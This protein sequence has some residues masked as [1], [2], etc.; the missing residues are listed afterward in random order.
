MRVAKYLLIGVG[1]LVALFVG[2]AVVVGTLE[3]LGIIEPSSDRGRSSS[4]PGDDKNSV[5]DGAER[6]AN[7]DRSGRPLLRVT[8]V[9][10][11][12]TV[13][14]D[15][16]KR[17]RLIG[18]DT[19]EEG[20][21][22]SN[23]ATRFTRQELEGNLVGYE[24][25]A[26]RRDRYG[27]TLAYLYP[28]ERMHEIALLNRGLARVLTIAPNDKYAAQFRRAARTAREGS[29]GAAGVCQ[30][31]ATAARKAERLR[32]RRA[33]AL[34]RER[35]A[36]ARRVRREAAARRS[37]QRSRSQRQSPSSSGGRSGGGGSSGFACGPGDIDGD[38]DGRCN[39]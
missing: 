31:R 34:R 38:N 30:R 32:R 22:G 26:E 20:R 17:V 1:V 4:P 8:R 15:R 28:T 3:G 27:R 18:V 29:Q 36:V 35:A 23:S 16:F 14:T 12:D 2:S 9:I 33:S 7:R 10:D 13:E 21:C 25:D 6:P 11:G 5:R 19:P 39:E 24:L 37:R